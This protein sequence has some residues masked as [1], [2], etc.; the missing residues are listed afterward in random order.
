MLTLVY[1]FHPVRAFFVHLCLN[2]F[3][4]LVSLAGA[5]W[6]TCPQRHPSESTPGECGELCRARASSAD[7]RGSNPMKS[8][9][10]KS[11]VVPWEDLV[12]LFE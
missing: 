6:I 11:V 1:A 7:V 2:Q 5:A 3:C 12:N 8:L 9:C 4:G 10:T